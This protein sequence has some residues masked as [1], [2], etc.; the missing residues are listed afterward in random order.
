MF[1][2][3]PFHS[4]PRSRFNHAYGVTLGATLLLA[5]LLGAL[6]SRFAALEGPGGAH[7]DVLSLEFARTPAK[8]QTIFAVWG[9]EGKRAAALQTGADFLFLACYS[10][11]LAM[12]VGSI[13]VNASALGWLARLGCGLAWGQW[14]AGGLDTAENGALLRCLLGTPAS[15]WP[16]LAFACAAAKFALVLAGLLYILALLPLCRRQTVDN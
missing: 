7:Y 6:G 14:V 1:E 11:W 8:M 13:A 12:A 15:P 4:L 5:V 2:K 10:T 3:P 16:E 9:E